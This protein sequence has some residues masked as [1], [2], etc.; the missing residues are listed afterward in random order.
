[1]SILIENWGVSVI[2]SEEAESALQLMED[3]EIAPDAR[4]RYHP[5][6]VGASGT[7]LFEELTW[8]LG[9]L[10]CAIVMA[11]RSVKLRHE[12][13]RLG[14]ELLLKPLDRTKLVEFLYAAAQDA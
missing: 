13:K 11:E 6:G 3:L 8:R 1:M 10:P 14:V 9:G 12:T 7:E 2:E 4:H 5:L